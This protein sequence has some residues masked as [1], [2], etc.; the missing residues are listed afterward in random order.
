MLL[1]LLMQLMFSCIVISSVAPLL[2]MRRRFK[3]VVDVLG[4][5]IR[6]GISLSRSVELTAQWERILVIGPLYPVALGDLDA[7]CSVGCW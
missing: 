2:D 6:S 3:A 5:R 7:G 4:A 1:T